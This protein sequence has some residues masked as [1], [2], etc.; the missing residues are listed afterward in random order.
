MA[1]SR[2]SHA[3]NKFLDGVM[4]LMALTIAIDRESLNV[5]Q[6]AGR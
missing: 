1:H 3:V 4:I 2:R 6:T 5:G